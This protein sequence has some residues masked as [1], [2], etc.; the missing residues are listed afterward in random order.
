MGNGRKR[1]IGATYPIRNLLP[2]LSIDCFSSFS[3]LELSGLTFT[4]LIPNGPRPGI[5]PKPDAA[6]PPSVVVVV[7]A[8]DDARVRGVAGVIGM[9]ELH[10]V[11]GERGQRR[12][13]KVESA[14]DNMEVAVD[15]EDTDETL[16][17]GE[18]MPFRCRSRAVG[19]WRSVSLFDETVPFHM[20]FL[21][22]A[23]L[24]AGRAG[25]LDADADME[26]A[27]DQGE[28]GVRAELRYERSDEGSW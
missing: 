6:L 7:V 17:A 14:A 19:T 11:A 16:K 15:A 10:G 4:S 3:S 13:L 28:A 26:E 18:T 20:K 2:A 24:K 21:R 5:P 8:T 23:R 22:V 1:T 25:V 27:A 12:Q 9:P